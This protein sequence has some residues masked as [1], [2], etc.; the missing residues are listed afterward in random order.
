MAR[1][2]CM[3]HCRN[4]SRHIVRSDCSVVRSVGID[5]GY[6]GSVE[7]RDTVYNG[8]SNLLFVVFCTIV[9]SRLLLVLRRSRF[10]LYNRRLS[11]E[12]C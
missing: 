12:E 3:E 9:R 8:N 6:S 7:R 1:T 2:C 10:S 5:L 11:A 4:E